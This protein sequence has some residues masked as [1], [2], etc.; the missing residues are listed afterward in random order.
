MIG[1]MSANCDCRSGAP[2]RLGRTGGLL[3]WRIWRG[4]RLGFS[5]EDSSGDAITGFAGACDGFEGDSCS[6]GRFFL[7]FCEDFR[8]GG[9]GGNGDSL[10]FFFLSSGLLPSRILP[11][12]LLP[13]PFTV[14]LD[15]DEVSDSRRDGR[16]C[17]STIGTS[18]S[19]A[20]LPDLPLM[21]TGGLL[22]AGLPCRT[23]EGVFKGAMIPGDM[24]DMDVGVVSLL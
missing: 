22:T 1:A 3:F 14:E 2:S 23:L 21:V 19:F 13:S 24:D 6:S 10:F 12:R 15:D 5:G 7:N 11:S 16:P 18:I 4:A 8:G 17:G 9:L 20:V